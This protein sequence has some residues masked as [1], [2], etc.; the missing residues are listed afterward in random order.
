MGSGGHAARHMRALNISML[1]RLDP[2][3][4][5]ILI[6]AAHVVMEWVCCFTES[7]DKV[8]RPP[9]THA[10]VALTHRSRS[11]LAAVGQLST[12]AV[13]PA[14][15]PSPSPSPSRAAAALAHRTCSVALAR[16]T[17]S[18]IQ[19]SLLPS[20]FAHDVDPRTHDGRRKLSPWEQ[21][22][23][24]PLPCPSAPPP[25]ARRRGQLR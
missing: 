15:S 20:I 1:R 12:L 4:A 24:A 10:A 6:T 11:S 16:R 22:N 13:A 8:G 5:N 3:V 7:A 25:A 14:L 21:R 9:Q 18:V 17:C 19:V 23:R 2:A